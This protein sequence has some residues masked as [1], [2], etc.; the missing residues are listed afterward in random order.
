[1]ATELGRVVRNEFR[2]A[3]HKLAKRG[4]GEEGIHEA[5]KS[6]KKIRAVLRI[7]KVGAHSR[8]QQTALRGVNHRLSYLR[9]LGVA[10]ATLARLR[11]R[12]PRAATQSV[13]RV[14]VRGL[15]SRRQAGKRRARGFVLNAERGL[16][17]LCKSTVALARD[18]GGFRVVRAG[19]TRG[20]RRARKVMD[21][22]SPESA[23]TL[24]HEW[25]RR[26]KDHWYQVRLLERFHP[27]P[28]G[29]V[30]SLR[31]LERC[32][33]D[34]HDCAVLSATIV[35]TRGRFGN[36]RA[37]TIVLGCITEDQARLRLQALALG[38]RLF[39]AKVTEFRRSVTEW[40]RARHSLQK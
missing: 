25:R 32:L 9:D 12:Y 20:Y 30:R 2:K 10:E 5:R 18:V 8:N 15:R 13:V 27:T 37:A 38:H 40:C 35:A 16:R 11:G 22:V 17:R 23:A 24:F 33:G 31:K 21:S 29:R 26:I 39:S 7:G 19:F 36:T 6:V 3:S 34:D 14:I 1:M 4:D 28:R